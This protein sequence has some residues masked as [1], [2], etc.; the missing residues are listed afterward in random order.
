MAALSAAIR[1]DIAC[2]N[3]S[4]ASKGR[5]PFGSKAASSPLEPVI[6]PK[7]QEKW[8]G[9]TREPWNREP[10]IRGGGCGARDM[11]D[12]NCVANPQPPLYGTALPDSSDVQAPSGIRSKLSEAFP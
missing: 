11:S 5:F 7:T 9:T 1:A 4:D 12:V 6:S 10:N 2:Q 8:N 3:H